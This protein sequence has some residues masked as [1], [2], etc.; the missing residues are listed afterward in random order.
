MVRLKVQ[1]N[2]SI[3]VKKRLIPKVPLPR[4]AT[5]YCTYN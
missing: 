3:A 5:D 1:F 2:I 4:S